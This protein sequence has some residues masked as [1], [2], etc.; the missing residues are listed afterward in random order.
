LDDKELYER[1]RCCCLE[2]SREL[3]NAESNSRAVIQLYRR[4][5]A[6]DS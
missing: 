5:M 3:F 2:L 4:A 1:M 6:C